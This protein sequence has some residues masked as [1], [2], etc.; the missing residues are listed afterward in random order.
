[1]VNAWK[2]E[3]T[4][5]NKLYV[6]EVK[7]L[8][9]FC[10]RIVEQRK[11]VRKEDARIRKITS[12]KRL[13]NG[14]EREG[15]IKKQIIKKKG[16]IIRSKKSGE[17]KQGK[18]QIKKARKRTKKLTKNALKEANRIRKHNS[19]KRLRIAADSGE[20]EAKKIT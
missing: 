14:A 8:I 18:K 19:R 4:L 13:R 10:R 9:D 5:P 12:R 15:A 16:I 1:M 17:R 7:M 2:K 11:L 20:S 3:R 6:H